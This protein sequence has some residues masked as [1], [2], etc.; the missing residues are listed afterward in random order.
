MSKEG[1]LRP[2]QIEEYFTHVDRSAKANDPKTHMRSAKMVQKTTEYTHERILE[3]KYYSMDRVTFIVES[4]V[5]ESELD[6]FRHI[7]VKAGSVSVTAN[8]TSVIVTA[9]H[10]VFVPA[11]CNTYSVKSGVPHTEILISY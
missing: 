6:S 7:F 1:L 4:A 2:L 5:F 11:G 3:T 8:G 10:S 9:G